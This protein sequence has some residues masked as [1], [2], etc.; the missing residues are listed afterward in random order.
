MLTITS[1]QG[2]EQEF[3]IATVLVMD[4]CVSYFIH[5]IIQ[6]LKLSHKSFPYLQFLSSECIA[7]VQVIDGA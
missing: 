5:R 1:S 3:V 7:G 6:S 4:I 2:Q